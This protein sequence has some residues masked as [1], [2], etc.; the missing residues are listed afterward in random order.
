M[1][2]YRKAVR[3]IGRALYK[4]TGYKNPMKKGKFMASRVTK[5]IPKIMKD[6][7]ILKSMVNSEKFR[8]EE[9]FESIGIA[10]LNGL[11]SG[12]YIKD[13]TPVPAQG[14]GYN[15]RQGN[16]IK[17]HSSHFD[18]FIQKQASALGPYKVI[19]ELWKVTGEPYTDVTSGVINK[20]FERNQWIDNYAVY[21][22]SSNRKQEQFKNFV[23]MRRKVVYMKSSDFSGQ[24]VQKQ[25][26]MG[27]KYKSHHVKYNNNSNTLTNGQLILTIRVDTGN[28][29]T[30]TAATADQVA[31]TAINTGLALNWAK[32][33]YYYDN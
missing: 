24:I 33:D 6:I 8:L 12:H 29:S 7:N 25:I 18:F 27:I 26:Q 4:K 21:D 5:Q 9:K 20:I 2:G 17:L 13:I 30:T 19:I 23:C 31:N 1:A 11:S 16:S 10:Q 15:N 3:N 32:H 22:T 14:D 28:Y